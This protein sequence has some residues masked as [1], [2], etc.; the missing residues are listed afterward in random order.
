MDSTRPCVEKVR[1]GKKN[2]V[3]V[4]KLFIKAVI[5]DGREMQTGCQG[6]P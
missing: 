2:I 6:V 1:G 4:K 3:L 5:R